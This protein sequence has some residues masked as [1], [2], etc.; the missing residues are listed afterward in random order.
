MM[1]ERTLS[2]LSTAGGLAAISLGML[3][4]RRRLRNTKRAHRK[5]GLVHAAMPEGWGVWFFQAF[6]DVAMGTRWAVAAFLL[7]FWTALGVGMVGV[8]LGW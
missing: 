3:M 5:K 7:T 1:L 4:T 2:L 6:T 8:G